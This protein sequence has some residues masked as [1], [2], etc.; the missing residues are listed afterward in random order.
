ME[1]YAIEFNTPASSC[2]QHGNAL[3]AA[4]CFALATGQVALD[5]LECLAYLP[6][7]QLCCPSGF[8]HARCERYSGKSAAGH[9]I[10]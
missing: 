7:R 8:G 2:K 4:K 3:P 10:Y 9:K 5:T 1:H 6:R